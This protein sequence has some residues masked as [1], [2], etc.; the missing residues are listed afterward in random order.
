MMKGRR[1]SGSPAFFQTAKRGFYLPE[2]DERFR[3]IRNFFISGKGVYAMVLSAGASCELKAFAKVNLTLDV[4]GKRADGYHLLRMVMQSVGLYD[5]VVLT[6]DDDGG[7]R[8]VC[9]GCAAE[10]SHNTAFLAAEAFFRKTKLP[11]P[12]LEIRIEKRIPAEAGMAGGSADAAAV[13]TG[14]NHLF[15]EPL[16]AEE[17]RGL[18]LEIG[19]DVPFCLCGSTMLAEGVGE[20]LTPLPP[21]PECLFVS[22]KPEIGMST[23]ESYRRYDSLELPP[24]AHPDSEGMLAAI[25]AGSLEGIASRLCNVLELVSPQEPVAAISRILLKNGALGAVMT[26]SGTAAFGIFSQKEKA[27]SAFRALAEQ[28]REVFLTGP[29][30]RG[31]EI[32]G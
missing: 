11:N 20:R 28:Y 23:A 21:I 1:I 25:T 16:S 13:L 8:L 27:E 2:R 14:L 6:P 12:G 30:R 17:L 10:P 9:P 15:G 4:T 32:V 22:A 19:A 7:I 31:V 5:R 29:V 26:G 3:P 18:G 24:S